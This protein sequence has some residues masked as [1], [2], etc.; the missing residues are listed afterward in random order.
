MLVAAVQ[1]KPKKGAVHASLQELSELAFKAAWDVD[2]DLL[3]LPEMAVTGY[4]FPSK[5]DVKAVSEPA[6]GR[7]FKTFS[8]IARRCNCWIVVGFPESAGDDIYN[9]ALVIDRE[10]E[11]RFV[12]RKTLLYEADLPWATPGDSGYRIFS[13]GNGDFAVGICMDINDD[14]FVT[15]LM[16]VCPTV[17]AFP[18]NWVDQGEKAWG[19]WA[20]RLAGIPTTLVAADSWGVDGHIRF[21]GES[22]ILRGIE[23]LAFAPLQ[24][25]HIIR[26][27]TAW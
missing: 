25:N 7:T 20:Y 26:A 17:L 13:T 5:E 3:V 23:L 10:G 21:R 15:W 14:R 4:V 1:Y 24:G 2:L 11:L 12:Y 9:S 22:A 6:T 19:Y 16:S 18:T 27:S 8:E